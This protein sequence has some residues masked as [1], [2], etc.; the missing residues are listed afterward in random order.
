[1]Q[2]HDVDIAKWIELASAVS[3]QSN[4]G[5]GSPG[6]LVSASGSRSRTEYVLQQNIDKLSPPTTDFATAPA[7]L[8][9]QTQPMFFNL[10]KF[11]VERKDLCRASCTRRGEL[12][13]RVRQDLLEMP[14]CC[15]LDFRLRIGPEP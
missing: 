14:G 8:V 15:H 1:V 10:E 6:R 4:Q 2:K 13:G 7:G 5:E 11:F 3:A 9:F 12:I